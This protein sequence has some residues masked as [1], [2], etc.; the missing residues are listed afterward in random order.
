MID[1]GVGQDDGVDPSRIER[2]LTIAG[3]GFGAA[4]LDEAAVQCPSRSIRCI[5]PVTSRAAP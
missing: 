1:V 4:A 5:D 2:E 3:V